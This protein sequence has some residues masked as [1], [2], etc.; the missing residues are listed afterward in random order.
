MPFRGDDES[1]DSLNKGNYLELINLLASYNPNLRNFLDN[2][3]VFSGLSND[4][5]NDIISSVANVIL[6]EIKKEY[7]GADYMALMLDETT[8][9]SN[10]SQLSIMFRY[11]TKS[12]FVVERFIEF[13]DISVGRSAQDL[14]NFIVPF[15]EK[16]KVLSKLVCQSYDGAAVMSGNINGLQSKVQ[17]VIPNAHFIHCFAHKLN[18]VLSQT[19]SKKKECASFFKSLQ[20]F[21]NFFSHSTK[22]AA[23]F[24]KIID[25]KIPKSAKTIDG[26]IMDVWCKEFMT[27][28]I[29]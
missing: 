10:K 14:F 23:E 21:N 25:K 6:D 18:L 26:S 19:I 29:I 12:G 8:D 5:Q 2:S 7:E 16:E 13:I 9:I 15:L 17:T 27:S 11:V 4:I 24:Q 1:D 3:N 28:K 22:R 20:S